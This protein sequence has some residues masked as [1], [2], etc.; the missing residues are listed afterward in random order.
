MTSNF[1]AGCRLVMVP[2]PFPYVQVVKATITVRNSTDCCAMAWS[3]YCLVTRWLR[4]LQLYVV[5]SPFAFV[6]D[7]KWS[8]PAA[9]FILAMIVFSLDESTRQTSCHGNTPFSKQIRSC[10]IQTNGLVAVSTMI[11]DPFGKK[12]KVDRQGRRR[13]LAPNA[14]RPSHFVNLETVIREIDDNCAVRLILTV[15]LG[16]SN[17]S[18]P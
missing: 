8:A 12:G 10:F 3:Q 17:T 11:E 13:I 2:M 1:Q 6:S 14:K 18:K 16:E 15:A 4:T 7:L 9:A 5:A